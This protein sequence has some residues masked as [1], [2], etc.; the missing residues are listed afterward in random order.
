[1]NHLLI[2]EKITCPNC[3][4]KFDIE[5]AF[6]KELQLQFDEK[7]KAE[8]QN[9]LLITQQKELALKQKEEEFEE[10][11]KHQNEIFKTQLDKARQEQEQVIKSKLHE[12]FNLQ[13]LEQNKELQEKTNKI[14]Q[15]QTKEIELIKVQRKLSEVEQEMELKLQQ[16]LSAEQR[17]IEER[18]TKRIS[19]EHELKLKEK[20]KQ[21]DDQRK[22]IEE[23]KRKSEQGSMQLQGEIQELALE[24]E[25][26]SQFPFDIIEEVGKGSRGADTVQTVVNALQQECG[27]IIYESKRTKAFSN[28]WI[29]KLKKDQIAAQA[30]IAVLVTE[31]LPKHMNQFG[32]FNGVW[33]CT[34]Q[35][36][37]SLAIVLREILIRTNQVKSS[38]VNKADKL[39]LLYEFLLGEEFKLQMNSIVSTYQNLRDEL[40]REKRAMEAI[41]K[42]RDKQLE[43]VISNAINMYGSIKG[44]GGKEI[45]TIQLLEL[46]DAD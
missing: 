38:Q 12:E 22:L 18:L 3:D 10:K 4:Y 40:E 37:K 19:E 2:M 43:M 16:K 23:M 21:L 13:L 20:E 28:E 14:H 24:Q 8:K 39:E 27:K 26:R 7:L 34:Y 36:F 42:R 15:L 35:E 33:I 25:L 31:T 44:I 46:G 5:G 1:M 29:D 32:E 11:R 45:P 30:E 41:W 9:L 17:N 6:S